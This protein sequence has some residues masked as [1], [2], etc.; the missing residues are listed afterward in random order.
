MGDIVSLSLDVGV[1][2]VGDGVGASVGLGVISLGVSFSPCVMRGCSFQGELSVEMAGLPSGI[3]QFM[4]VLLTL[5][6][7]DRSLSE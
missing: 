3:E 4:V 2:R 5:N 6:W 1:E 7:E